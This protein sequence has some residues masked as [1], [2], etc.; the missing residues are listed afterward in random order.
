VQLSSLPIAC[1]H[2]ATFWV[3]TSAWV[4]ACGLWERY[5]EADPVGLTAEGAKAG[6]GLRQ[7]M[8]EVG[9]CPPNH[10]DQVPEEEKDATILGIHAAVQLTSRRNLARWLFPG[11]EP[12]SIAV[13]SR[14]A[15]PELE[16]L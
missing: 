11:K 6:R 7:V 1:H 2:Q 3:Y 13:G 8:L 5:L 12:P 4:C 15:A 16:S 10:D 14:H 9:V